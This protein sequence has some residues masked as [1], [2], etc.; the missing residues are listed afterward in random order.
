[1]ALLLAVSGLY[2]F[3]SHERIFADVA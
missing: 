1:M 2:Y 3:R